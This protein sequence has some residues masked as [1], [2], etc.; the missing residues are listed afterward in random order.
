[1]EALMRWNH[2]KL[3]MIG[4]VEFIPLLE[5]MGIMIEIGAWVLQT[6]CAQNAAWQKEGLAPVWMAVNVSAQ[7]FYR[8]GL[9]HIVE[10]ALRISGLESKWLELELT[11][12]LTL[13]DS[14]TAVNIMTK[15]KLLG[16]RLSLDDFGTGWSSLSYL[17]RFPLDRLKID[18]SFMRDI[19]LLAPAEAVVTSIIGLAR[20]LGMATIAEGV[21][22]TQQLDY[23]DL[24]QCDEIQG[25]IYS[26][27][28][29]A[30]ECRAL[31]QAGKPGLKLMQGIE[32][33]SVSTLP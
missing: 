19:P 33:G 21:E 14:E 18:Q 17:R 13:D 2:P 24:K 16:V 1:V 30:Q 4:P 3:G 11:E 31:M 6:A 7:Q 8:G 25:F 26:P 22:T 15:L 9:V 5:Q 29:P 23:L 28:L 27:P 32:P 10:E 20:N 12:T